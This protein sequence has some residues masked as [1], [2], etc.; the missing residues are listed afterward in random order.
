MRSATRSAFAGLRWRE[1]GPYRGGRS[2]A[3]TGNPSRPNEFWMGTT[4]GGVFKS[5]NAGQSWA[6][7][8]DKYFGGTIG[9]I[10][11]AP[12]AP[13]VVYVGG[14]EYPIRGNV[15]HGDGVW[16]TTDGG[17]TWTFMGLGDTRQIADIVVHP[18]NPDLVYVGALGHVWA[19]NPERG[20]FRSKDGGKTW[21]K[22]LFRNDSTGVVDLVMDPNN[23]N[24]LYAAL[25]QAGRTPWMLSSGGTGSGL[26]KTTDGGD[27]WTEIT[28]NPGS[29]R[30][31]LGQHRHHGVRRELESPLGEHRSRFGRR[32]PLRRRAARRGRTRT[33]IAISA[34]ARGTTRRS[35]PI[36]RTRTSS[37]TTTCR[38]MK[39]T[40]GGKTFR[41]VRGLPHGD[42]HDLWIDPKN[43][44]RMIEA[45]DGGVD[46]QRSTA[47]DLD[48]RGLRDRAVLSRR[49]D[50]ALPVS[51]LRRAAG[52]LHA[53]RAEPRD[54]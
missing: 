51:H 1:I 11:V 28:R 15:S 21:E 50:D 34:S 45:D 42:S 3:V 16:K 20:V 37:T 19:P 49:H 30:R 8:T 29:A 48:R 5:I 4:G 7:V 47:A 25:W 6:P 44:N 9:A 54:V 22:I 23:P 36:R 46:G 18:T 35:T 43:S 2:V 12:S 14:G 27:H 33:P 24:V 13:D 10:A 53:L 40:D 52:Q 17:K 32:V 41:P 39:S 26:F 38:F 31:H